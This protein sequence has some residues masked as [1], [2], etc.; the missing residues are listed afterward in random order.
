MSDLSLGAAI[1]A[2]ISNS[3]D[4][5]IIPPSLINP[6]RTLFPFGTTTVQ[7]STKTARAMRT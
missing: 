5:E 3:P 7:R 2:A 6:Q 1:L 4:G